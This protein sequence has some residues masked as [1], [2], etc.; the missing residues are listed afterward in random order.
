VAVQA[1]TIQMLQHALTQREAQ[2]QDLEQRARWLEEQAMA[3]RHALRAVEQGRVMRLLRW[4]SK[5]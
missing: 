1:Q 3:S 4:L 2:V 5:Q